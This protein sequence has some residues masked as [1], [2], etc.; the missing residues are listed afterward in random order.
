MC[1][2]NCLIICR[3]TWHH[4][5]KYHNLT[6]QWL[7][8]CSSCYVK[9]SAVWHYSSSWN[10][11]VVLFGLYEVN[12][13]KSVMQTCSLYRVV[14]VYCYSDNLIPELPHTAH[15]CSGHGPPA[16][17]LTLAW[18]GKCYT[19]SRNTYS[20][21]STSTL[22]SSS[23]HSITL[24]ILSLFAMDYLVRNVWHSTSLHCLNE[25]AESCELPDSVFEM[26]RKRLELHALCCPP[27][28]LASS[29]PL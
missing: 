15:S 17:S 8:V 20:V 4:N 7:C 5:T 6:L 28:Q 23:Q 9:M 26:V 2:Q 1:L 29:L 13:V 11:P 25:T 3:I 14:L 21:G 24:L 18:P 12:P 27:D 19:C 16:T 22:S 10:L